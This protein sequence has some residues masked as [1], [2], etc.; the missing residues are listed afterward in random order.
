MIKVYFA[1]TKLLEEPEMF[2]YW[3]EKMNAMRKSKILQC[4]QEQDKKRSLLAGILLRH[5]LEQEGLNYD[6]LE[7]EIREH[8]KPA[9][10][11][12][13]GIE[14]SISHAG[15]YA[16]CCISDQGVGA[17]IEVMEKSIFQNENPDKLC[18][19]AKKI[20]SETE[21]TV[22]SNSD[23][24]K[25]KSIFLKY[26]TRKESYSKALGKGLNM[27][28]SKIDTEGFQDSFWSDWIYE[29]CF[30]SVYTQK[31]T[32]VGMAFHMLSDLEI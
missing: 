19:M 6:T 7:F 10:K 8:G 23:S 13:E 15:N 22:F 9:L 32:C 3:F 28:F 29:D 12:V 30:A 20:L 11:S 21:Y 25:K 17:D 2:E 18:R 14:F 5:A 4:R 31:E 24:K 26:W 16:L 1:S 27:D